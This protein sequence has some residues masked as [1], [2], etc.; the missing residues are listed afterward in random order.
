MCCLGEGLMMVRDVEMSIVIKSELSE[1][2]DGNTLYVKG[3]EEI[4]IKGCR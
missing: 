1:Y 2:N 3:L 4:A